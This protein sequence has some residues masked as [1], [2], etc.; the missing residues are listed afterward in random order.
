MVVV[1]SAYSVVDVF[2]RHLLLLLLFDML[3]RQQNGDLPF[4]LDLGT[5]GTEHRCELR[6]AVAAW[7]SMVVPDLKKLGTVPFVETAVAAVVVVA[8]AVA[9]V[10]AGA[11]AGAVAAAVAAVAGSVQS[12]CHRGQLAYW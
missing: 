2:G 9:V 12:V 1:G 10:V 5:R 8:A 11:G 3:K 7:T 4:E 6:F